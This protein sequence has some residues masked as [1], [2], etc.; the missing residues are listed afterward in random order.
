MTLRA[1]SQQGFPIIG[2]SDLIP[3]TAL[4]TPE[5]LEDGTVTI[6]WD[7]E[8]KIHWNGQQTRE[9][10]GETIYV[11]SEEN[12]CKESELVWKEVEEGES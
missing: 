12:E 2:T 8:T 3:G 11:D 5:R 4:G 1:F 6:D 10:G 7:G 9:D